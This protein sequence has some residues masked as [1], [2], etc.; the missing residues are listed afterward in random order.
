MATLSFAT[1]RLCSPQALRSLIGQ[2]VLTPG[3]NRCEVYAELRGELMGI[4]DLVGRKKKQRT[5]RC[6]SAVAVGP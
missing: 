6:M 2:I 3:K 5:S 4:L 1:A